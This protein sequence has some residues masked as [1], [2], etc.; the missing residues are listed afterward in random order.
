ML[1][2]GTFN[3]KK[4]RKKEKRVGCEVKQNKRLRIKVDW[5]GN[6]VCHLILG[7]VSTQ[8]SEWE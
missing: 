6:I 7:V 5:G 1:K 3:Q 2:W 4:K 8:Y